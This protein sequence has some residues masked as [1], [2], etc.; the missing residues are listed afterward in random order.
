LYSGAEQGITIRD[1]LFVGEETFSP[2]DGDPGTSLALPVSS[3]QTSAI[4][5]EFIYRGSFVQPTNRVALPSISREAAQATAVE[6]HIETI[7]SQS[8]DTALE[9]GRRLWPE[10]LDSKDVP[11]AE[12]CYALVANL[13]FPA[14]R[15]RLWPISLGATNPCSR[16]CSS[17]PHFAALIALNPR[18]FQ[19]RC[20]F[21]D[22][23]PDRPAGSR[24]P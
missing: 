16:S 5:A 13:Q 22:L 20:G 6:D 3:T 23:S 2:Y 1:G 12:D 21:A 7:R 18:L 10:M 11:S 14:I 24:C 19:Q 8:T 15:D 4:N 9:R 17:K